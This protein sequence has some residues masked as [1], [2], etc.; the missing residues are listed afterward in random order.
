M[1]IEVG[2][3]RIR[4]KLTRIEFQPLESEAKLEDTL[5]SDLSMLGPGLMLI[6]RQVLTAFGKYIDLLAIDRDG[7]LVIIELKRDKTPREIIAQTLDYASWVQGLSYEQIKNI[8]AKKHDGQEF[9][10]GY[11]D[12]YDSS[13]PESIN[14]S[15]RMIVV[16]SELDSSTERILNYLSDN[17]G[18][19]INT[20]F[21]RYFKDK[22]NEYLTRTWL[23]DP[24]EAEEKVIKVA[25]A[26]RQETWN[27]R[28]F[29]VSLG[30][31]DD[32]NWEDCVRYGFVCGGGGKWYSQTLNNLFLGARVFVNI[33][34]NGYVGV[35]TVKE[36]SRPVKDFLVEIDGKEV[37]IL[38]APL[39]AKE[40]GKNAGNP[41]LCQYFVRVEWIKTV[42]RERAYWEKGLFAIQHTAC[43]MRN[44]FTID[45][46]T[47]HLGLGE[48]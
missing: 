36:K 23:I 14:E 2:I 24:Q 38:N 31:Y 48:D 1:P 5:A 25:V 30:E 45:K 4:N 6:G 8:Y 13:P 41:A 26:K 19:P 21:F 43:K 42:P 32:A 34:Q 46:L 40:M 39:T 29:Y 3:W 44:Q 18:V 28:D 27:G 7:N 15:H 16:A 17:Y 10:V 33:P 35:G 20:V 22:D 47:Q 37:P 11:S 9:E 12:V